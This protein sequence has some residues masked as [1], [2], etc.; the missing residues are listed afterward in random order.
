M[1][2]GFQT[3]FGIFLVLA[4]FFTIFYFK[5]RFKAFL[6]IFIYST[7]FQVLL[8]MLTQTL[9]IFVYWLILSINAIFVIGYL[10]Y[11]IRN[12]K[13]DFHPKLNWFVVVALLFMFSH[14]SFV[15][16]N[17]TG[18]INNL[19][20]VSKVQ[21]FSYDYPYF[22]DEWA[23]VS[24]TKYSINHHA[25]P[26]VNPLWKNDPFPNLM[27]VYFSYISDIMLL[28]KLDPLVSIQ[29]V[30]VCSAM[31]IGLFSFLY[32]RSLRFRNVASVLPII[33]LP[34]IT[35]GANLP[36]LW[37]AMPFIVSFVFLLAGI[38]CLEKRESKLAVV[39]GLISLVFY[40]PMII[41]IL[42]I[43]L[44]RL[45]V[46][47]ISIKKLKLISLVIGLG[48]GCLGLITLALVLN[49]GFTK[50]FS[51]ITSQVIHKAIDG[52]IPAYAIWNILPLV[53]ILFAGYG[54]YLAFKAKKYE[55][56]SVVITGLF[57]WVAYSFTQNIFI[58][59]YPRVVVITAIL[60]VLVSGFGF[61][62]TFDF[63]ENRYQIS[64]YG[65]D[66]KTYLSIL[67]LII[68]FF[69]MFTYTDNLKWQKFT[70]L[71]KTAQG[72]KKMNPAP[73]ANIYLTPSDLKIFS[74]IKEKTFIT[75]PWKGLAIG[76][77]TGNYPLETKPS[78]ITNRY[79]SYNSFMSASCVDKNKLAENNIDFVYSTKLDC[80]SFKPLVSSSEGFYLYKFIK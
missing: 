61:E 24:L 14:F 54:L 68:F 72:V 1:L 39:S 71:I 37:Y 13:P 32:L 8:A 55:V 66:Y 65:Q 56:V 28:L 64:I 23:A 5:N 78:T 44:V 69:S 17:Y 76:A 3:L 22:S 41:F 67:I 75:T 27:L 58:I 33:F 18:L 29:Y 79:I 49:G 42:P 77:A 43:I 52:G 50:T 16:H 30:A 70:M 4:P 20:G 6:C 48:A 74:L 51:F 31:L 47:K 19:I 35:N 57:F 63:I 26:N 9:G 7:V 10:V 45:F 34:Y 36:G 62:K 38:L 53:V 80:P 60:L 46:D 11:I 21:N 12:N 40:P 73:P 25:L 2:S 59:D 15:H